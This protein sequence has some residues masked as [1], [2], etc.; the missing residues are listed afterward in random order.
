MVLYEEVRSVY[1]RVVQDMY[2]DSVTAVRCAVGLTGWF[3]VKVGLHQGLA[4]SPFLFAM[5]MVRVTY[6]IRQESLWTM[7]FAD[8]IVICIESREQVEVSLEKWRY[9]LERRGTKVSRIKTEY[10]CIN[11][12]EGSRMVQL[13]GAEVVKVDEFK[14]LGSV[15]QSNGEYGR[16][17]N[18]KGKLS[19]S[20]G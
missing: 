14:Y 7:M 1:V 16:E 20:E 3:K 8:Y 17:V 2:E 15:I 12:R 18:K 5:V 10:M 19:V 6:G 4:L 9:T 11:G 13:Q